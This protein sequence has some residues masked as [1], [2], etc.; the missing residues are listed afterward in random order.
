MSLWRSLKSWN[1]L[2]FCLTAAWFCLLNGWPVTIILL[3]S[4]AVHELGHWLTLRLLGG[5]TVGFSLSPFGAELLEEGLSY[6]RELLAVLAGPGVNLLCAALLTLPPW[7]A[8]WRE[9]AIGANAVLGCFNLLPAA[10]LDGWRAIQILL[11]WTLGPDRGEWGA[12]IIGGTGALL[13]MAAILWMMA[14]SGGNLWLLPAAVGVGTA[15]VRELGGR[16]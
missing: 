4:A 1:L 7:P 15:G 2:G 10:P 9:M 6:P 5:K 3:L 14:G 12:A 16:S 13:L 11:C 8:P